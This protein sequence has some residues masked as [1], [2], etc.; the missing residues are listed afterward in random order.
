MFIFTVISPIKFKLMIQLQM[1][2]LIETAQNEEVSYL[3]LVISYNFSALHV[4]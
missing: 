2:Y 3:N 4:I 1:I